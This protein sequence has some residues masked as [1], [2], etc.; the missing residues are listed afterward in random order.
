MSKVSVAQAM[1]TLEVAINKSRLKKYDKKS[2][3]PVYYLEK[4]QEFQLE[5]FNPTKDIILAKI[6]LNGKAIS[7]GGLILRQG[8]R[9]FLE[10]YID[11]AKKFKFDTYNVSNTEEVKK[12]IEDNGDLRVEF[13]KEKVTINYPTITWT[14]NPT[15]YYNNTTPINGNPVF[16][17]TTTNT[18]YNS[19]SNLTAGS[20]VT[21]TTNSVSTSSLNLDSFKDFRDVNQTKERKSLT[22]SKTIET[23]RVEKGSNSEQKLEYVSME[24]ESWAFH[25]IEYKLLPSSRKMNT[26][27]DVAVAHY[28]GSCG[29]KRKKGHKFCPNCGSRF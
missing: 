20:D 7:Q 12:A 27:A 16:G 9:V 5:L 24:F 8:E 22:R 4:G 14:Y 29:S 28:C 26:V 25:T 1:P 6:Y 17:S 19:T 11:I 3:T 21:F 10:R 23:G 18:Y 13:Y 15:Y 2:D